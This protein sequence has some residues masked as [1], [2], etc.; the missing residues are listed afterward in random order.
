MWCKD[1]G[2]ICDIVVSPEKKMNQQP[3]SYDCWF[4]TMFFWQLQLASFLSP[5]YPL[6]CAILPWKYPDSQFHF[7]CAFLTVSY[8]QHISQGS[9]NNLLGGPTAPSFTHSQNFATQN[10]SIA[11]IKGFWGWQSYIITISG[12]QL[13]SSPNPAIFFYPVSIGPLPSSSCPCD[14]PWPPVLPIW[15]QDAKMYQKAGES[16]CCPDLK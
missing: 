6:V 2:L 15:K 9:R 12:S 1:G 4:I 8:W 13:F 16:A 10:A 11:H 7:P 3:I 5:L 14:A